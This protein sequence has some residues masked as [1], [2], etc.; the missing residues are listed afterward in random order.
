MAPLLPVLLLA[1]GPAVARLAAAA[2]LGLWQ[3]GSAGG[4][5]REDHRRILCLVCESDLGLRAKK[6]PA[7]GAGG[8]GA[9]GWMMYSM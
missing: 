9:H 3:W 8:R 7:S 4:A 5:L 6:R 1:G 2:L